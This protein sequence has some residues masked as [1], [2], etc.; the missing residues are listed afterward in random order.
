M[1]SGLSGLPPCGRSFTPLRSSIARF[2]SHITQPHQ[3]LHL[4][5][6]Q[7]QSLR[8]GHETVYVGATICRISEPWKFN[9]E[10]WRRHAVT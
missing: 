2:A 9:N 7:D 1:T 8:R 4:Y 3:D 10:P 6:E 5:S